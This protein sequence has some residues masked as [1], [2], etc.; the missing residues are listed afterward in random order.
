MTDLEFTQGV[1]FSWTK[2]WTDASGNPRDLTGYNAELRVFVDLGG[3]DQLT[4]LTFKPVGGSANTTMVL[5]GTAGTV[6]VTATPAALATLQFDNAFY[7]LLVQA[8]DGTVSLVD[9][10]TVTLLPGVTF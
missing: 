2:T 5:G 8:P 7:T 3:E 9:S 6:T 1:T 4:A 10:G